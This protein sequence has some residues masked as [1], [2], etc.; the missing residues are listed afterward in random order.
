M[1]DIT[2][3]FESVSKRFALSFNRPQTLQEIF[4]RAVGVR[5]PQLQ[6][7]SFWALKDLDLEIHRGET[8]GLI[9]PNGAGK[10]TLLKLTSRILSP[11]SGRVSVHGRV[12][13]L[14]ELGTGFH[15]DLT[16]RENIYLNGSLLGLGKE[17]INR[18]LEA[19][20]A[21]SGLEGFID[22]PVKHYSTGMYMRLG[23]SIAVHVDPDILLVDEVLAVG[24]HAF[25][26]KCQARIQELVRSDVT[27]LF[28]SHSLET[29]RNI[30]QRVIWMEK[31]LIRADGHTEWATQ[32]YSDHLWKQR[33]AKLQ[34]QETDGAAKKVLDESQRWGSREIEINQ[35]VLLDDER[36]E[37]RSFT[38]GEPLT[39]RLDYIAHRRVEKPVFGLAIYRSDGL[40]ITGPNTRLAELEIPFLEGAGSVTYAI[41]ALPLLSGEY[42]LSVS[43]Y[44][45]SLSL[46]HDH[47]HRMYHF[48]VQGETGPSGV[49]AFPGKWETSSDLETN[50]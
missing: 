29:V 14:L 15:P 8:V 43:V 44:D 47:H 31:G 9:G 48:F 3:R 45:K 28:V 27:I 2:V 36:R 41:D 4:L 46:A 50:S 30:C 24:D 32:V 42:D 49:F 13:A 22:V 5:R 10:S 35:V 38:T 33:E 12:A 11:T 17:Q 37:R 16:G 25:Q 18:K 34:A 40:Y 23:F 19:I 6:D 26:L 20:I 39:I 7:N 1:P 21:F